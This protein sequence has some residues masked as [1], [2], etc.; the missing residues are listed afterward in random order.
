MCDVMKHGSR[1]WG[2]VVVALALGCTRAATPMGGEWKEARTR[3]FVIQTDLE[4][5]DIEDFALEFERSY[6][7]IRS[8]IV[9]NG[10]DPPGASRVLLLGNWEEYASIRHGS[11]AH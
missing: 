10:D 2:L 8:C 11:L 3:H 7:A 6:V 5:H 4:D 9:P 1:V